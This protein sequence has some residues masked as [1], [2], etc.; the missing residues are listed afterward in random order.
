MNE[1]RHITIVAVLATLVL[2][3]G[4]IAYSQD[5]ET[6]PKPTKALGGEV[7]VNHLR[8]EYLSD[9]LGIDV[10][11]PR[12]S[13]RIESATRGEMQTAYQVLVASTP[14]KLAADQGDLWESGK[15]VAPVNVDAE[16]KVEP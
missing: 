14:E 5:V 10:P 15:V 8:C 9:P 2:T 6:Q 7:S 16:R 1:L 12:L 11:Q 3:I 13:W 4:S